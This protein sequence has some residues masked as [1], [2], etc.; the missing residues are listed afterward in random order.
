MARDYTPPRADGRVLSTLG[1]KQ[2]LLRQT[3]PRLAFDPEMPPAGFGPW[4][5]RVREKLLELM[6]FPEAPPQPD[7]ERLW[8][9][10]REG[11][12]LEKW[13]CYP[14]PGSVVPYLVLIPDGVSER[15]P[16]PAV[17]C[18]PGSAHPKEW[19]AGEPAPWEG[20]PVRPHL[21]K[22]DMA[23]QVARAGMVAVAVDNPGTGELVEQ[24]EALGLSEL[25]T[26]RV[27]LSQDLIAIGRSY[28]GL[29][30]FQKGVILDW[31]KRLPYVR[32]DRIALSAHSL[33]TEPAMV[34]GALH[35]DLAA[36]VSN[37]YA[38]S[39]LVQEQHLAPSD[40]GT[41]VRVTMPLWHCIPDFWLWLDLPDLL[42]AIA[43][44]PLLLTEGGHW[45]V[46]DH[47]RSAYAVA[48]A[49][50]HLSIHHYAK[51]ADPEARVSDGKPLPYGLT[52]AEYLDACNVDVPNHYFKGEVAVP[53]LKRVLTEDA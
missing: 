9:Q 51:Y 27:K 49:P 35:P 26:G 48:G 24:P 34:L 36:V 44:T 31:A 43:P 46:L 23:R 20:Y 2:F 1:F 7:P 17:L 25:G 21:E 40:D 29:S 6:R 12:R 52:L 32:R 14:E 47:I 39:Q 37:D 50:D 16:A 53:W 5:E 22:N 30:A 4:K 19:L 45:S 38:A 13:E 18:F 10:P 41:H 3:R 42:A 15:A 33:G 28:V 8:S 11:Y